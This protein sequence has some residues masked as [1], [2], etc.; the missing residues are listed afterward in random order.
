MTTKPLIGQRYWMQKNKDVMAAIEVMQEET[1][2]F[3]G[4]VAA[5]RPRTPW[6]K[7]L[8]EIVPMHTP[9]TSCCYEPDEPPP[10]SFS[11]HILRGCRALNG[12]TRWLL[13]PYADL[14]TP[15]TAGERVY[16]RYLIGPTHRETRN[17]RIGTGDWREEME[18]P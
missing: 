16:A 1:C 6:K 5:D 14:L 9:V 15:V 8:V 7:L 3:C 17:F 12:T 2:G 13:P 4:A 18:V 10:G 11:I